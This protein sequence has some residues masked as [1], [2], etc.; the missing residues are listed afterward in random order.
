MHNSIALVVDA[1]FGDRI[2]ALARE[3][4]VWAISSNLNDRAAEASRRGLESAQITT[5]K[6]RSGETLSDLITRA[7]YAIEEHHG[8]SSQIVP[9]ESLRIYGSASLPLGGVFAEL[10]FKTVT[11]TVDALVVEK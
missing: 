9:Y 1:E 8:T 11:N 6:V 10:G 5:I 2:L 4:P 3:M 7:I